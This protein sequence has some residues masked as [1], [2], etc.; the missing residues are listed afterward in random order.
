MR[1]S[2][3]VDGAGERH[4][5]LVGVD[6][7][8]FA[9]GHDHAVRT[10]VDNDLGE[11]VAGLDAGNLHEANRIGEQAGNADEGENGQQH[12]DQA[13]RLFVRHEGKGGHHR[14][15]KARERQNQSWAAGAFGPVETG[16]TGIL[17]HGRLCGIAC[18]IP[19]IWR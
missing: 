4:I 18:D 8:Q 10:G 7:A 15:E 17:A 2:A 19:L 11:V 5:S 3:R 16:R 13:V 1:S 12:Q 6:D 9:L 14:D